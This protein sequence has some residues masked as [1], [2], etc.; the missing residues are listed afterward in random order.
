MRTLDST[1][2]FSGTSQVLAVATAS[3]AI[4][5]AFGAYTHDIRVVSGTNCWIT[6]AASPTATAG[7]GSIYLPAGVVE[8]FH[9]TPG[10]KLA[11]IR[12]SA[13][14]T[15]SVAEMTR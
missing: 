5:N 8:Y 11:A 12:D 7:A 15:L 10:Q 9:V 13:D 14:G 6:F 4:T 1:L 3:A 2:K